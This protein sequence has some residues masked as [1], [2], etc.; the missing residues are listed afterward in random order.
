M[1]FATNVY[2]SGIP[3]PDFMKFT[4]HTSV[5]SFMNYIKVTGEETAGRLADP[6]FFTGEPKLKK[7]E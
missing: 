7:V 4:A 3:A 2:K 1:S 5:A 6:S